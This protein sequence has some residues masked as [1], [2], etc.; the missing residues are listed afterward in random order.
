MDVNAAKGFACYITVVAARSPDRATAERR[1]Q[2]GLNKCRRQNIEC[3]RQNGGQHC[4]LAFCTLSRH[5]LA[6]SPFQPFTVSA[7]HPFIDPA[8]SRLRLGKTIPHSPL[9]SPHFAIAP[10][11]H[12]HQQQKIRGKKWDENPGFPGQFSQ[13]LSHRFFELFFLRS[14]FVVVS[15]IK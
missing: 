7:L 9:R 14:T 1:T 13:T 3:R 5:P 10:T 12:L 8:P 4:L 2:R 6:L 11:P 15:R